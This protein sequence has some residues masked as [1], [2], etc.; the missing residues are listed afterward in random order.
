MTTIIG[1]KLEN[2]H[3]NSVEFQRVLM[4]SGCAIRTRIGLHQADEN[5]CSDTGLILLEVIDN[6]EELV[7][8]LI[9][10]GDVKTMEF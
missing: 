9:P 3:L 10:F 5:K 4:E 1:I 2:R 7:S 6:A 8:K